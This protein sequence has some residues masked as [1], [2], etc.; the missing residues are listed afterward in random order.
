MHAEEAQVV[1]GAQARHDQAQ[2]GLG[3]GGFLKHGLDGVDVLPTGNPPAADRAVIRK[4]MLA[5]RVHGG[6][7]TRLALGN[8]DQVLGAGGAVPADV[9]MVP[10]QVK[11]RLIAR[12]LGGAVD[13]VAVS[14]RFVL[15]NKTQRRS[16]C[17]D[18]AGVRHLVIGRDNDGNLFNTS[19]PS[20]LYQDGEDR[21]LD[22]VA[23]DERLEGKGALLPAGGGDDGFADL[24]REGR[25]RL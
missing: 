17:T 25:R 11:E 18:G 12:E 5:R 15:R 24:H 8:R 21:L 4:Q 1:A 14:A 10:H 16:V 2:L 6:D 9:E 22:A 20:L 23:I 13:G 19:G 7:G 3:G